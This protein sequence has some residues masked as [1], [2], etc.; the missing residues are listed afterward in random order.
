MGRK[1]GVGVLELQWKAIMRWAFGRQF[2]VG[3]R[4]L[5]A[6]LDLGWKMAKE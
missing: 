5:I 1:R 6:R 3:G 2:G 4:G